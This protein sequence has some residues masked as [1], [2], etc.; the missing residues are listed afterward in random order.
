[1][2]G[3][4]KRIKGQWETEG[5]TSHRF[6]RKGERLGKTIEARIQKGREGIHTDRV[7]DRI[8]RKGKCGDEREYR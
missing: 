6:D 7:R 8:P 1:M 5:A 4:D 2:Q 3:K